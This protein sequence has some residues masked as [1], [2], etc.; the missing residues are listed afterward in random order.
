MNPISL[1]QTRCWAF[2]K[3][4]NIRVKQIGVILKTIQFASLGLCEV[5]NHVQAKYTCPKC[6]VKTCCLGCLTIHKRELQ[7]TGIRDKTKFI[8][9]RDMTQLDFVS[10]YTFLEECTRYVA[11]RKRDHLKRHTRYNK[12]LPA[13][14]FKLRAAAGERRTALRFL[15]ALFSR[16]AA[17]TTFFDWKTC[18]IR[19]RVEWVFPNAG[20]LVC[21][22]A[23]CDERTPLRQLLQR[24]VEEQQPAEV[25]AAA[26]DDGPAVVAVPAAPLDASVRK[27]LEFYRSRGLASMRVLLKAEG[28]KR[29]RTRF[30]ELDVQ[31]S[32]RANL[33]DK[34]IVEF[35]VVYVVYDDV[36]KEFDVIDSGEW[37]AVHYINFN[38]N[39]T[40]Q[41]KKNTRQNA[42]QKLTNKRKI[43]AIFE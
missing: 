2:G 29:S 33:A 16:R 3:L 17:N 36:V 8:A 42:E 30:W 39:F 11:D 6:E 10:D 25:A 19:W 35:P 4:N 5:C 23:Q 1:R 13:H 41:Q 31:R 15:L 9:M 28:I 14:L 34:T 24:Y 7:C 20:G 12:S 22:D 27:A 18:V 43:L 26:G 38:S 32:L 37:I 21:A 40:Q